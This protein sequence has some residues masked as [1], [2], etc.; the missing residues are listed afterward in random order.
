MYECT[1]MHFDDLND[2]VNVIPTAE[3]A[4][5]ITSLPTN[6][7]STTTYSLQIQLDRESIYCQYQEGQLCARDAY[8]SA[9]HSMIQQ[10]SSLF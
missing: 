2:T 5:D 8:S 3:L 4:A 1:S 7:P 6:N 9:L 10:Y